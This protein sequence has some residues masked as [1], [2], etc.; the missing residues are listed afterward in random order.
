MCH[1][2]TCTLE[3]QPVA[4]SAGRH[5]IAERLFEWG[6]ESSDIAFGSL[7][8]VLLAASELLSNAVRVCEGQ[9][10]GV[11]VQAHR[12][13]IRISVTDPQPGAAAVVLDSGPYAEGGRG[14]ALVEAVTERWGQEVHGG[15]KTVWFAVAVPEGSC[16]AI[17]CD[18]RDT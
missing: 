17:G 16:L 13:E 7:S 8:D 3:C 1:S 15:H 14:L 12:D 6:V 2:A 18:R 11:A 10:I 5:F 9:Q 4:V